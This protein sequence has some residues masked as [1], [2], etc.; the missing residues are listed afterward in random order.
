VK[1]FFADSHAAETISTIDTVV[2][3]DQIGTSAAIFTLDTIRAVVTRAAADTVAGMRAEFAAFRVRAA[4]ATNTVGTEHAGRTLVAI[5]T[6]KRTRIID[7]GFKLLAQL[8]QGPYKILFI[9]NGSTYL[10]V[11]YRQDKHITKKN[12]TFKF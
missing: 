11:A 10:S 7:G 6:L 4:I 9:H 8:R 2:A 12:K 1:I 3:V 5:L